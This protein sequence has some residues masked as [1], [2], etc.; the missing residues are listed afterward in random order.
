MNLF[1]FVTVPLCGI[2][3]SFFIFCHVTENE[4]KE[5]ARVPLHPARR[6]RGRRVSELAS[7]KQADTLFPPPPPMLGAGQRELQNQN[8]K[9]RI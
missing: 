8:L 5:H 4:A 1:Q 3:N 2:P 7:L 6:R 9:P